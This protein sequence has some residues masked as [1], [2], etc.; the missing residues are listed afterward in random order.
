MSDLRTRPT[1]SS[2]DAFIDAVDDEHRR[3][4]CRVVAR[5]MAEITGAGGVMWGSSIVGFGSYHYRY[6]SGRE[7]DFFEAGFSPRKRALT[8]Y[9]MAGFAEYEDLL[10][11]LGKHSTGKSCLYVKRLADVDLAVLREMLTRSVAFIRA[12]YP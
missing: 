5:L 2:V 3:A 8:I 1:A 6:A 12:K 9:V 11:R 10:A 7:G 4:D